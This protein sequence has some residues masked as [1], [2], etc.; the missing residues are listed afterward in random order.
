MR[1]QRDLVLSRALI[2]GI[3]DRH[4]GIPDPMRIAEALRIAYEEASTEA[5]IPGLANAMWAN[6]ME[7]DR[8][9]RGP[10]PV[11]FGDITFRPADRLI[12]SDTSGQQIELRKISA[13]IFYPLIALAPQV[14]AFER[15]TM[16]AWGY[17][18]DG[19]SN[20]LRVQVNHI[21][22]GLQK[23]SSVTNVA[24]V[25]KIGYH[26]VDQSTQRL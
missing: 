17:N 18:D 15:L 16:F 20:N 1:N 10:E 24:S 7:Q 12:T 25:S 19:N 6:L 2:E 4:G 23:I 5:E 9:R 21:R 11:S 22:N 8:T 13:K 26:L 14:I 3:V